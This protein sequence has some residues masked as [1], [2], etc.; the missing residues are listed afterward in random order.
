MWWKLERIQPCKFV[1]AAFLA[2][3]LVAMA[4]PKAT[5][6]CP[7]VLHTQISQIDVF[8]GSPADMAYLAPSGVAAEPEVYLL[9][10]IYDQGGF[11]TVRCHYGAKLIRDVQLRKRLHT[12][13][14]L[15]GG[16]AASA[17]LLCR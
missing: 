16:K 4:Q 1:L 17:Q 15:E 2:C 5:S 3:P 11:V 12:C 13:R 14:Y 6:V 9:A 7:K 10:S 8:D